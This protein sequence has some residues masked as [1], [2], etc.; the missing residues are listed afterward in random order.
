MALRDRVR[1]G[2]HGGGSLLAGNQL[3]AF[4]FAREPIYRKEDVMKAMIGIALMVLGAT[5]F[6]RHRYRRQV[7]MSPTSGRAFATKSGPSTA[8]GLFATASRGGITTAIANS[9]KGSSPATASVTFVP[10]VNAQI[11]GNLY[12]RHLMP[13]AACPRRSKRGSRRIPLWRPIVQG[14]AG[15]L[16]ALR[17]APG[18][19]SF[20]LKGRRGDADRLGNRSRVTGLKRR[21]RPVR[22]EL[23]A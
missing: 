4:S 23:L 18:Q 19:A 10:P 6:W 20:C 13:L 3:A 21:D 12:S 1:P 7:Q 22:H 8:V 15:L 14:A 5:A 16:P 9:F 2:W 17:T 11:D